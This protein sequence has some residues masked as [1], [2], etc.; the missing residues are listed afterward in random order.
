MRS[1]KPSLQPLPGSVAESAARR[2]FQMRRAPR[3][4]MELVAGF[5]GHRAPFLFLTWLRVSRQHKKAV[6]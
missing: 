2:F 1:Q 6:E 5:S 4:G 3:N